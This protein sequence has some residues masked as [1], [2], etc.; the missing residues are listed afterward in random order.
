MPITITPQQW[1]TATEEVLSKEYCY[2]GLASDISGNKVPCFVELW[3]PLDTSIL[4]MWVMVTDA[5][6]FE[7]IKTFANCYDDNESMIIRDFFFETDYFAAVTL[8][9]IETPDQ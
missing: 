7:Q 9:R 2:R 3:N 1:E 5:K 6:L 8:T 4:P